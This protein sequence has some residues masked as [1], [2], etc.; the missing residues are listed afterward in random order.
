MHLMDPDYRLQE[1]KSELEKIEGE[2]VVGMLDNSRV[3]KRSRFG[4]FSLQVSRSWEERETLSISLLGDH[5]TLL[6]KSIDKSFSCKTLSIL[7]A[8]N[9]QR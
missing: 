1:S 8:Q 7:A 2:R 9:S 6:F 4:G 5:F 3:C